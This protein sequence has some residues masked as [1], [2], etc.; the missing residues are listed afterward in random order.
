MPISRLDKLLKSAPSG[1]LDKIIQHAQDMDRLTGRLRDA[2]GLELGPQ[3]V[4]ANLRESGELVLVCSTS[5]W[6][7]R[8]RFE[9]DRL[10][11]AVRASGTDVTGCRVKVSP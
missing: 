7:A 2:L 3:L 8:F 9:T 5:A 11:E 10:V 4:A 1:T 6:A